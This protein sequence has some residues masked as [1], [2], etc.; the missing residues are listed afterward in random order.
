MFLNEVYPAAKESCLDPLVFKTLALKLYEQLLMVIHVQL[1]PTQPR[2]NV[3]Q[4][5]HVVE[6]ALEEFDRQV[7]TDSK[8][9][10]AFQKDEKTFIKTARCVDHVPAFLEKYK[11]L[12]QDCSLDEI[13][14]EPLTQQA[15]QLE[16]QR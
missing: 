5:R 1:S 12:I 4:A 11:A 7:F 6:D 16:I 2:F 14:Q 8:L 3:L 9:S 13:N 10:S 15:L